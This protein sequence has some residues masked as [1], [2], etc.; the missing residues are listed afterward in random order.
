MH[1]HAP[2]QRRIDFHGFLGNAATL[3]RGHVLECAHVV[4]PVGE[5]D[6]Q[7]PHIVRD[8]KQE[9]A[10]ILRLLGFLRHK[11][12]PLDLGQPLDELADF[13]TEQRVDLGARRIGVLDRVMQ[14]RDGNGRIIKAQIRQ[15]R[16]DFK[17]V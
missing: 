9:L 10:E 15:D 2:G 11:V 7:N 14:Q 1:P 16:G 17:R 5:L 6:E 13:L 3:V 4:E 8:R 12:K